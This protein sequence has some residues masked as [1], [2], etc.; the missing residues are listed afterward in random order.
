MVDTS[1]QMQMI[2]IDSLT[3][4]RLL[5]NFQHMLKNIALSKIFIVGISYS[6]FAHE[7]VA[8]EYQLKNKKVPI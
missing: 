8:F 1:I 2:P 7:T 4:T 3:L 5:L 6:K